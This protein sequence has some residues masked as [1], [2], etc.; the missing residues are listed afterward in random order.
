M[1]TGEMPFEAAMVLARPASGAVA[2]EDVA[3][4]EEFDNF[5]RDAR[6]GPGDHAR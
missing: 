3:A 6:R 1:L 2:P 4:L 5:A